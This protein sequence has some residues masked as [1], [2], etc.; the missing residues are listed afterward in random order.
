MSAAELW[1]TLSP[2]TLTEDFVIEVLKDGLYFGNA[3]KAR[4]LQALHQAEI[5][6]V[7]DVAYEESP[8]ALSRDIIYH[9]IPLIDGETNDPTFVQAA[10]LV[11]EQSLR[12]NLRT[13]VCCSAGM[14]RSP[15]IAVVAAAR[16]TGQKTDDVLT[17]VLEKTSLGIHP[18]FWN[19]AAAATP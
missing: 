1:K 4:D 12:L 14:S 13:L 8:A 17:K 19:S 11:T 7:V 2:E 18:G 15:T 3:S 16:F 9:R 10:I 6:A 5:A